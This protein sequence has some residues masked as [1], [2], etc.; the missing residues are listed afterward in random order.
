MFIA[1]LFNALFGLSVNFWM[2]I[3][4][5]FL[6][7]SFNCLLGTMKVTSLFPLLILVCVFLFCT[8]VTFSHIEIVHVKFAGVPFSEKVSLYSFLFLFLILCPI[9]LP[10]FLWLDA[11]SIPRTRV[12]LILLVATIY[13][14]FILTTVHFYFVRWKAKSN[15]NTIRSSVTLRKAIITTWLRFYQQRQDWCWY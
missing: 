15:I 1:E 7:G 4:M 6:L 12:C 13:R 9:S 10:L 3:A 14:V 11:F 2:A 8:P 5:R